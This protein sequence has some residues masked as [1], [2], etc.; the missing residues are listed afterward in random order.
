MITTGAHP[1]DL[2]PGVYAHFGAN[3]K[4]HEMEYMQ[5]FKSV[6]SGRAFEELVQHIGLGLAP[7]KDQGA[8]I[9]FEDTQQG[10][11]AR[12]TPIT[13]AIGSIVTREA[14]E[15]GLYESIAKRLA[16]YQAFSIRQTLENVGANILNRA[17]NSSYLGGDS[18]ELC[19][20]DHPTADGTQSNKLSPAA[21]LSEASLE[22]LMVQIGR[23]T[24]ENGLNIKLIGRK[25]II[26]VDRQF[27]ATRIL[28]SAGR[29]ATADNDTNAL[30]AMGF[31]PDGVVV[32]HYL[33]DPDAWFVLTDAP[34][35]LM[36]FD[37]RAVEFAQDNDFDTENAKMKASVRKAFGWAS[38]RHVYG[39]PGA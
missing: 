10:Y 22:D 25:L 12:F 37:R 18:K 15:D 35:G 23:A 34:E 31:L 17:F 38:W 30:R 20:T 6:S 21:D 8:S 4:E 9:S 39:S 2:W 5:I 14:I 13:Y 28:A 33:S 26:P 29:P 3:Y 32:S 16:R 11:V 24:D 27:E 19:A 36:C 1:K 7:V